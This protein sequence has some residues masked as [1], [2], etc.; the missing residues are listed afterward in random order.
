[1]FGD[2]FIWLKEQSRKDQSDLSIKMDNSLKDKAKYVLDS[3][4]GKGN[5]VWS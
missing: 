3:T 1:M 2:W 4:S 5:S